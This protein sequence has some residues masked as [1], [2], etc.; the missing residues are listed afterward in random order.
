MEGVELS[1][2][3]SNPFFRGTLMALIASKLFSTV[4]Q[5]VALRRG[6][7]PVLGIQ[8]PFV[9]RGFG[10]FV[11]MFIMLAV[12]DSTDDRTSVPIIAVVIYNGGIIL[13][14][15]MNFVGMFWLDDRE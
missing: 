10:M 12:S 15:V 2:F 6:N 1:R 4:W 14:A 8:T 13:L 3:P 5:I 9:I 11:L 7:R